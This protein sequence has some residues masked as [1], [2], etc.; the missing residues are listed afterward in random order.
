MQEFNKGVYDYIIAT[1]ESSLDADGED[2]QDEEDEGEAETDGA[3]EDANAAEV[4]E[5]GESK[6][7]LSPGTPVL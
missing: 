6:C 5:E 2:D 3:A 1:D 7:T 4:S